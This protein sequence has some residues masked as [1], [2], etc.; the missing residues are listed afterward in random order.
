VFLFAKEILEEV[1]KREKVTGIIPD[2]DIDLYM[3][4]KL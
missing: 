4:V 3:K 2:H 1:S